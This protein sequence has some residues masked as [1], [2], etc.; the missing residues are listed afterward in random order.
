M[1]LSRGNGAKTPVYG[2]DGAG[3]PIARVIF[4]ILQ[5][6]SP[7][8]GAGARRQGAG[9]DHPR[10]ARGRYGKKGRALAAPARARSE[11]R[12]ARGVGAL[13]I[14]PISG[15]ARWPIVTGGWDS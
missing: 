1:G 7:P 5:G 6:S 3:K 10:A 4:R 8:A 11:I 15:F 9:E 2:P 14:F 12:P 13:R